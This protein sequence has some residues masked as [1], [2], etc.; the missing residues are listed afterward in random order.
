MG[1]CSWARIGLDSKSLRISGCYWGCKNTGRR[2][3]SYFEGYSWFNEVVMRVEVVR[4]VC[5]RASVSPLN[6][7]A[8]RSCE[9]IR[10]AH[11]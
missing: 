4:V 11:V 2:I 8:R 10:H 3:S 5:D 9:R 7:T 6:T 1:G